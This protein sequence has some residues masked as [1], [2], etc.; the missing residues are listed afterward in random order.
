[1][2]IGAHVHATGGLLNAI[3]R[4]LAIGAE[5]I[6]LFASAPQTWR[7][8]EYPEEIG[9][10]F[11]EKAAKHNIYPVF[12]HG[13]YLINLATADREHLAR[14]ID[15][16][17]F[18]Q[19]TAAFIGSQGTIFHLGSHKGLGLDEVL[20]QIVAALREVLAGSPVGPW[21]VLEN[22]A[23]MGMSIGSKFVELARIIEAVGDDRLRVCLDTCHTFAAGYNIADPQGLEAA[24]EEFDR[25]IG[26]DKLVAIHANDSKVPLGAGVDRHENIG[27]GYIGRAGFEVIMRHPAFAQMPFL[28]EVP[29][30]AKQGP[31]AENVTI[32]KEIREAVLQTAQGLHGPA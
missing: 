28:L 13:V 30:F 2:R 15:S 8:K 32:L 16:L 12:F 17:L 1:M 6:Q 3:D 20:P 10:L 19:R 21:L 4:A 25:E 29:G 22:S 24:L 26:F 18:Y 23:G 11:R 27:R 31:D 5:T 7:R 14:S 9:I